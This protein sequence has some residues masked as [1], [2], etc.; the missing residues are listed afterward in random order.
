MT[1]RLY[2]VRRRFEK[3][4]GPFSFKELKHAYKNLEIDYQDE[5]SAGGRDWV[6]LYDSDQV[7][8]TYPEIL[9]FLKDDSGGPWN[10]PKVGSHTSRPPQP[11]RWPWVAA[12]LVI[13]AA[14]YFG[15]K[16]KDDWLK[17][18]AKSPMLE[19]AESLS[20]KKKWQNLQ[21]FFAANRG[22]LPSWLG[23]SGEEREDWLPLLREAFYR[24]KGEIRGISPQWIGLD[25]KKLGL[26]GDCS[27]QRWKEDILKD[28]FRW[29][30]MAKGRV[31]PSGNFA[32]LLLWDSHWIRRR[33]PESSWHIPG[34]S[35]DYCATLA[36][37]AIGELVA[38]YPI[39]GRNLG[40]LREFQERLALIQ[41]MI[42][43]EKPKV[44][45]VLSGPISKLN[46]YE[47]SQS[48]R[49]LADC[50]RLSLT[51]LNGPWRRV[52]QE[53]WAINGLRVLFKDTNPLMSRVQKKAIFDSFM[54]KIDL[55]QPSASGMSYQ[56]DIKG[57]KRLLKR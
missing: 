56:A 57:F 9:H 19:K 3:F 10:A 11:K 7:H 31:L 36:I 14:G 12:V 20:R 29:R 48:L 53:R 40:H 24:S 34:S 21:L 13:S 39:S 1:E 55:S 18:Y 17:F 49:N 25:S 23:P 32:R 27:V 8:H 30:Q 5:I 41:D 33:T 47:V 6:Y 16:Y 22:K 44:N 43:R 26:D 50:D 28:R 38:T 15:Y 42:R 4:L 51:E 52:M 2:L 45:L 37:V 35:Y 54:A 46:C